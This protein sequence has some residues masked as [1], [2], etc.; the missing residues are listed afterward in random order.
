MSDLGGDPAC[1]AHMFDTWD[2]EAALPEGA[3]IA[4]LEDAP[5]SGGA[6][7]SLPHG[8]DL[9]TNLIRLEPG[10]ARLPQSSLPLLPD[11]RTV[12]S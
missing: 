7:L 3:L 4:D 11:S 12:I 5:V 8:G 9:D 1:W 6:V 2:D 10:S